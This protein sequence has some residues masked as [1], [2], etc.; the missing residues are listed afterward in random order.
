MTD[1]ELSGTQRAAIMIMVLD[2]EVAKGLL[3][4][5]TDQ[6]IQSIGM[7][8]SEIDRVPPALIEDVVREFV[9]E[10]SESLMVP[11]AG[12]EFVDQ[13][14]PDLIDPDRQGNII[15]MLRRRVDRS[16]ER[17]ISQRDAA[18]VAALLRDERPQAQ[19]V[20]LSLMGPDNAARILKRFAAPEQR[21]VVMRMAR[22][23]RIPGELADDVTGALRAALGSSDDQLQLG[24]VDATARVLGQMRRKDNESILQDIQDENFDMADKLRRRMVVFEDLTQLN[25]RAV[26]A[27]I[28]NVDR[29]VLLVA[30]QGAEAELIDLFFDNVSTNAAK[31]MR[32]QMEYMEQ[33]PRTK[34][35]EA[36]ETITAAAL[37]LAE[38]GVI[39]LQLGAEDDDEDGG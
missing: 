3:R 24:G 23:K 22:L 26:Q 8:I 17:F 16:F 13:V 2:P 29:E 6:E 9:V 32:E 31:D 37:R 12:P 14:L 18:A 4:Q 39:N 27:L 30:L 11:Q 1:S 7:A 15:P 35:R 10:L 20:A 34:I 28:K 25:S 36:R 19:A 33:P 21:E 38:E 5:M